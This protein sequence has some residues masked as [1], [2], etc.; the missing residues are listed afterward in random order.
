MSDEPRNREGNREFLVGL[1]AEELR[2]MSGEQLEVLFRLLEAELQHRVRTNLVQNRPAP[3]SQ[4]VR[5]TAEDG[6]PA[7]TR[8]SDEDR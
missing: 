8:A 4:P 1:I 7:P 3:Q 2:R 5:F 6:V